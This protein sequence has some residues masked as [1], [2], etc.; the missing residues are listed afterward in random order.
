VALGY[1]FFAFDDHL[2]VPA[3]VQKRTTSL[4]PVYLATL[5]LNIALNLLWVPQYGIMGAAWATVG[6]FVGFAALGL[7]SYRKIDRI[8]YPLL[9]TALTIGGAIAVYAIFRLLNGTSGLF[10]VV[11]AIALWLFLASVL[12]VRPLRACRKAGLFGRAHLG[13]F[14]QEQA[15]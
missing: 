1:L 11:A 6:T 10:Q 2:R 12:A 14:T 4:L 9:D 8:D 3:L 15:P 13:L 5:A 7:I